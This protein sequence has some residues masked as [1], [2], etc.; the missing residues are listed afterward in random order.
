MARVFLNVSPLFFLSLGLRLCDLYILLL[1]KKKVGDSPASL[2]KRKSHPW[3]SLLMECLFD[4]S[5]LN[6]WAS[7]LD[8]FCLEIVGYQ[9]VT[10]LLLL[11]GLGIVDMW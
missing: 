6:I 5:F 1:L 4:S 11:C 9:L 10:G 8:L 2:E 3:A 7:T